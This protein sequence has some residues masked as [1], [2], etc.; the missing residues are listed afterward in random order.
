VNAAPDD[1]ALRRAALAVHAMTPEDREWLLRELPLPQRAQLRPLLSELSEIGIPRDLELLQDAALSPMAEAGSESM[2]LSARS[3][4]S[5]A[6]WLRLHPAQVTAR[7]LATSPGWRED[8]LHALPR[9]T[10][11]SLESLA[12]GLPPAPEL[13]RLVMAAA[14]RHLA[15]T[16]APAPL[17]W[18]PSVSWLLRHGKQR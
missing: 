8:L 3:T 2:A 9:S 13:E 1:A 7:L 17:S 11:A 16:A 10:R 5:L 14:R 15:E 18:W 12:A 6:R 4:R